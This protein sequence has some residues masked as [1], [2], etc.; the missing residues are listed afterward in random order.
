MDVRFNYKP[1]RYN[2]GESPELDAQFKE[3]PAFSKVRVAQDGLFW[4]HG[5]RQ[6]YI[7]FAGI[8]RIFRRVE[9][10]HGRLCCGGQNV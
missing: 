2:K 1:Y 4:R 8:Q 6:H 10:V 5:L 3:A 9:E 7:P